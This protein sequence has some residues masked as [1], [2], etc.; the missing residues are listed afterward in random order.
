VQAVAHGSISSC[1]V[2]INLAVGIS[3]GCENASD[4]LTGS[5][6][7]DAIGGLAAVEREQSNSGS[8]SIRLERE[9]KK[10]EES[11]KRANLQEER[12]ERAE[13]R[14]EPFPSSAETTSSPAVLRAASTRASLCA[15]HQ[16]QKMWTRR[17]TA[18][19]TMAMPCLVSK[20]RWLHCL[21]HSVCET[22]PS[23]SARFD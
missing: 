2:D 7:D 3:G 16:S 18:A 19:R 14:A 11:E 23:C 21:Q 6:A 10:K 8:K 5:L 15:V 12:L 22:D 17:A 9:K 13:E 4:E 1:E 20:H